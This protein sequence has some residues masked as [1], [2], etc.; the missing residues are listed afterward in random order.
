MAIY[1]VV[2]SGNTTYSNSDGKSSA[3][4]PYIGVGVFEREDSQ[5]YILLCKMSKFGSEE[6]LYQ[7]ADR[8]A[9][10][11]NRNTSFI[12]QK[13]AELEGLRQLPLG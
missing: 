6:E 11:L 1:K 2:K 7:E 5:T 4:H 8:I 9:E 13:E 12:T 3:S 10:L